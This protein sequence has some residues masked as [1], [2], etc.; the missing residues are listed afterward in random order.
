[1]KQLNIRLKEQIGGIMPFGVKFIQSKITYE[2]ERYREI[3][4]R[5]REDKRQG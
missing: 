5:Q 1:M 4:Y 2:G 3:I